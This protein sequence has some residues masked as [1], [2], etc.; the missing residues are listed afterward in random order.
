MTNTTN[1]TNVT[2][3]N[4]GRFPRV[5]RTREGP[6]LPSLTRV[7]PTSAGLALSS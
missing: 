1:M 7:G 3:A 2:K 5:P 6:V 4:D